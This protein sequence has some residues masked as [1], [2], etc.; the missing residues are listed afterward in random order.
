KIRK[1]I[2]VIPDTGAA[3][4][5]G[6]GWCIFNPN[7]IKSHPVE[8]IASGASPEGETKPHVW[9]ARQCRHTVFGGHPAVAAVSAEATALCLLNVSRPSM[10]RID[11]TA[12]VR[13]RGRV[14]PVFVQTIG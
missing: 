10:T 1:L 14:K 5:C 9:F 2:G 3:E 13:Y 7:G 12:E 4:I 6:N 11:Q 8:V